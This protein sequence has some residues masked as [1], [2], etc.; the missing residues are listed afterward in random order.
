MGELKSSLVQSL[1][2][3]PLLS[4]VLFLLDMQ[5]IHMDMVSGAGKN[6]RLKLSPKLRLLL[7]RIMATMDILDTMVVDTMDL[8]TVDTMDMAMDLDIMEK[9]KQTISKCKYLENTF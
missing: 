2:V 5:L 4:L 3:N 8:D 1:R 9:N 7:T 6:V